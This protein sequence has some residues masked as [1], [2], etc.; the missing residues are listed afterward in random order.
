MNN[1]H[2]MERALFRYGLIHPLPDDS[3]KQNVCKPSVQNWAAS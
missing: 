3:L 2:D 1:D